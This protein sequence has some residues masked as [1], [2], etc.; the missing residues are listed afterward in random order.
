MNFKHLIKTTLISALLFGASAF[1]EIKTV[2]F[3]HSE[4]S[5]RN[6]KKRAYS[7]KS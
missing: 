1:A 4:P 3:A 5:P 7:R 2:R 6:S